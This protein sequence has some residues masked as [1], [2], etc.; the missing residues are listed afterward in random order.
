MSTLM[1]LLNNYGYLFLFCSLFIEMLALPVPNELLMSYVGYL[2]YQ[3]KVNWALAV[4]FGT[5]GCIAGV[6][7][8]YWLGRHLGAPFFYKYGRYIHIR[9]EGMDK[10][11]RTFD[12]YGKFLLLFSSFI[13]GVR[14]VIGYMSG[15]TKVSFRAY[16]LFSY[17]GYFIWVF[18]FIVFGKLLGP[19]YALLVTAFKKYFII[20]MAAL[21]GLVIL[22]Y[23]IRYNLKSIKHWTIVA[24]KSLFTN[25]QSRLRLKLL[26]M[27][28]TVVF[29]VLNSVMFGLTDDFFHQKSVLFNQNWIM[30]FS[31]VVSPEW[32]AFFEKSLF[33]SHLAAMIGIGGLTC[34]LILLFGKQKK[35]EMQMF[36]FTT[37]GGMLFVTYLPQLIGKLIGSVTASGLQFEPDSRL[38]M[39]FVLYGYFI[40][41]LT[42][43][44]KNYWLKITV[45]V[46]GICLLFTTGLGPL[47]M[48][49]QL[50]SDL[51][52]DYI[53]AGIW[54]SFM[55]MCL[56]FWRLIL[57]TDRLA[58]SEWERRT[59]ER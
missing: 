15:I 58:R 30:I 9:K 25:F 13:P 22:Y 50:P 14:H 37:V 11:S 6:T 55:I 28:A 16:A 54:V 39:A 48:Q 5:L 17:S 46:L 2:A 56:E 35:L 3:G 36:F 47:Y 29:A 23:V 31:A 19:K 52:T 12:R 51:M 32:Y 38:I 24:Y 53:L 34:A 20:L 27:G 43:Y 26:I 7:V 18:T 41:L 8:T 42:R 59:Q 10:F 33:L 44:T 4:F 45:N 57:I 40:Y 21:A 1:D 49:Y